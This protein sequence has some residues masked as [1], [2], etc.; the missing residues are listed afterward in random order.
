MSDMGTMSNWNWFKHRL[1][2]R[3]FRKHTKRSEQYWEMCS[4]P[5]YVEMVRKLKELHERVSRNTLEDNGETT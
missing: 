2:K 5:R 4:N 3:L 1:R